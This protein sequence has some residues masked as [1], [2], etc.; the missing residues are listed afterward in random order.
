MRYI[1]SFLN[2]ITMYRLVLYGLMILAII[3]IA[4][5][6][7]GVLPFGGVQMTISLVLLLAVCVLSNTILAYVFNVPANVESSY[8]TAL[9]LFL[10]LTPPAS[11]SNAVV[12]ALVGLVSMA[13]KYVLNLSGKHIFNPVAIAA[14]LLSLSGLGGAIW[15]I[16]SSVMLLPVV[17]IGLLMVRKIRWSWLFLS[18][19][20]IGTGSIFLNGLI[21]GGT[22]GALLK[23][24]FLSGPI[25]FF[26]SIMLTE[27]ATTPPTRGKQI[28]Y[29]VLVGALYG[30]QFHLGPFYNAPE[31]TLIL[32]NIYSYIVS[33]K[34]KLELRLKEKIQLAPLIFDYVFTANRKLAFT[35]GQYM[36]WT[37]DPAKAD[38]R[39]NRRYFT[40]ASSPMEKELRIGVK[41]PPEFSTFKKYLNS[42]HPGQRLIAGNLAGDFTL[43]RNAAGKT[44]V[45]IAGGIGVTP[46][47]SIIKDLID[48]NQKTNMVLFYAASDPA[49]F[50]YQDIFKQGE[51]VGV[52]TVYI[53]SGAKSLPLDWN[54]KTGYITEEMIRAEV[55][56]Y[57]SGLY[58]LSGPNVMVD[59]YKKLLSSLKIS[60]QNI[61]TD[62]FPG[63]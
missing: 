54:G 39:G 17:I 46:F 22:L 45:G 3:A 18:F 41:V 48:T 36:E 12:I 56:D 20:V 53:L 40:I 62:Y 51:N 26:G 32:G 21:N 55:P 44:I 23:G 29:G 15:W 8:I 16:G 10:I 37:V 43:P 24:A 52:K 19:V 28:I 49:E 9:I 35:A 7:T 57:E 30:T 33:P 50:V 11:L 59:A 60:Q 2:S 38:S 6:F 5:S 42:M 13:S 61:H 4:F 27:P 25:I 31:L 34:D 1:D 63:Y 14:V 47:R 58:Y